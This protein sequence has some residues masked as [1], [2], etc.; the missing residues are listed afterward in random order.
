VDSGKEA[1]VASVTWAR[2]TSGSVVGLA[3]FDSDTVVGAGNARLSTDG[4]DTWVA[5]EVAA[6]RSGLTPP[7]IPSAS[8]V[9]TVLLSS[10][11]AAGEWGP[12][13][14]SIVGVEPEVPAQFDTVNLLPYA[15]STGF[16]GRFDAD[17][18]VLGTSD[19]LHR[20]DIEFF[21]NGVS[22]ATASEV[23]S[24]GHVVKIYVRPY[25]AGDTF[26]AIYTLVVVVTGAVLDQRATLVREAI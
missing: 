8:E 19:T 25:E 14:P 12:V 17:W 16:M 20:V 3:V 26:H 6:G 7:V 2:G 10:R 24:D 1:H 21:H 11:N 15:G 22:V 9:T 5:F 23:P 4:G 18:T 13:H